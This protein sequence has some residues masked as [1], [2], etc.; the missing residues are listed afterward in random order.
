L[1]TTFLFLCLGGIVLLTYKFLSDGLNAALN[2]ELVEIARGLRGYLH[3]SDGTVSLTY[4]ENDPE[5]AFFIRSA[6]RFYQIYDAHTGELL[7][8]SPDMEFLGM[9]YT[10]SELR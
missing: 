6:S 10:P 3:F 5:E 7:A 4:D 2:D 1:Y 9:R 8:Q